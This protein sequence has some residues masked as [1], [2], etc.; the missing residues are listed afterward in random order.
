MISTTVELWIVAVIATACSIAAAIIGFLIGS[1]KDSK[2]NNI[3]RKTEEKDINSIIN[4]YIVNNVG[5][6]ILVFDTKTK[7]YINEILISFRDFYNEDAVSSLENFFDYYGKANSLK[8]KLEVKEMEEDSRNDW[9]QV[10]YYTR[11]RVYQIKVRKTV[12]SSDSE[13]E[14]QYYIVIV[15]D[16]T[17]IKDY[18]KRQSDLAANVTHE[19]KTPITVFMNVGYLLSN[20]KSA[21]NVDV[22]KISEWGS[23][24]YKN[25]NRMQDIVDSFLTLSRNKQGD[26]MRLFD[27]NDVVLNA[28]DFV[29]S[30]KGRETVE[31]KKPE[32]GLFPIM[33]GDEKLV[34][35]IITNFLTNAIKYNWYDGKTEQNRAEIKVE[36]INDRI[37]LSVSDNGKGIPEKD[38]EHITERFYRVDNSGSR[39]VGGAGLGL[40]IALEIAE[41][42]DGHIEPV[43]K[44]GE[45]S[46]FTLFLSSA[47]TVFDS[48]KQDAKGNVI[49]EKTIY[50]SAAK[51]L[52]DQIIS[53]EDEDMTALKNEWDDAKRNGNASNINLLLKILNAYS[54][55]RYNRLIDDLT[56]I[57]EDF[58]GEEAEE[59]DEEFEDGEITEETSEEVIPGPEDEE[60]AAR[61]AEAEALKQ[62]A[63]EYL[64]QDVFART[65]QKNT[66][67]RKEKTR[68]HPKSFKDMYNRKNERPSALKKVLDDD[69][70]KGVQ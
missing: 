31:I 70:S 48:V 23:S 55:D 15:E 37:A 41:L 4:D 22:D 62:A 54:D 36:V 65:G 53:Q 45:G 17:G 69:E 46:T 32:R 42:H 40:S 44:F 5:F 29:G 3:R 18:E 1:Y 39:Q 12:L 10:D 60:M 66:T 59:Y 25:S 68:I 9:T 67:A 2:A 51:Y 50:Q 34:Q 63:R 56:Y 20:I 13:N 30:Y 7:V 16:V 27:L 8:S 57:D 33:F 52:V 47:K 26:R 19:L 21:E 35:Q 11:T 58:F 43:S 64:Q 38:L 24:L 49:Q 14:E 6:G 28:Y 61:A